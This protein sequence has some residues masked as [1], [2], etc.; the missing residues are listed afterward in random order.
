MLEKVS[1]QLKA[2]ETDRENRLELITKL[3]DKL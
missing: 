3:D 2:V 1:H